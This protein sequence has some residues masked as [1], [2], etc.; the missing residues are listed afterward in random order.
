MWSC[1]LQTLGKEARAM[2]PFAAT[3]ELG[4]QS[5]VLFRGAAEFW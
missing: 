3:I 1:L 2:E 5:F 4:G